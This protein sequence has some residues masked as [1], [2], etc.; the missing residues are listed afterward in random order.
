MGL[1][2]AAVFDSAMSMQDIADGARTVPEFRML[3]TELSWAASRGR[4]V[5]CARCA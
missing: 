5:L 4:L 2:F 1:Q 3:Q